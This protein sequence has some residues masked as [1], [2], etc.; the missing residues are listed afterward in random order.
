MTL[1]KIK[2]VY[3]VMTYYDHDLI[4]YV[5]GRIIWWIPNFWDH[6]IFRWFFLNCSNHFNK[7]VLLLSPPSVLQA[8]TEG[9]TFFNTELYSMQQNIVKCCGILENCKKNIFVPQNLL[10]K[11]LFEIMVKFCFTSTS[12]VVKGLLWLPAK[13]FP[14]IRKHWTKNIGNVCHTAH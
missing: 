1:R 5:F 10:S 9:V 7:C 12:Y 8:F 11:S 4:A 6:M 2:F 13:I 3:G 14:A